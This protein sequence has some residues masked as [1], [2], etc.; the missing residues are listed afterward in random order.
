[1][2]V[3][4]SEFCDARRRS[5]ICSTDPPPLNWSTPYH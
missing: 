1:L 2:S 3:S 4:Q 5:K